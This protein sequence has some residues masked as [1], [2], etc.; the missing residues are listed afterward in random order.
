[1]PI[2]SMTW[3][4]A[5]TRKRKTLRASE[6][7][8]I[9]ENSKVEYPRIGFPE[10]ELN[11]I[12]IFHTEAENN[13]NWDIHTESQIAKSMNACK[14]AGDSWLTAADYMHGTSALAWLLVHQQPAQPSAQKGNL[15][16]DRQRR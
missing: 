10:A 11:M 16:P 5:K 12:A 7:T 2:M 15:K 13:P 1:M 6:Q 4:T 9:W 8:A 3:Q 14:L